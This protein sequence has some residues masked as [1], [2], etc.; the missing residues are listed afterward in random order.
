MI[1]NIVNYQKKIDF[2]AVLKA[3]IRKIARYA[4][5]T[6]KINKKITPMLRRGDNHKKGVIT[7]CFVNNKIIKQ[8]NKK[9]LGKNYPTDVIA[10]NMPLVKSRFNAEIAISTDTA[11]SN[12]KRYKTSVIY[13]LLLYAAHGILHTI[14]YD[15]KTKKQMEIMHKKE[16]NILNIVIRNR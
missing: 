7:I 1:I 9:H 8:L 13:E 5:N 2:S 15:D 14:G 10:F 16:I 11:V 4:L 12:A 3:K 6:K